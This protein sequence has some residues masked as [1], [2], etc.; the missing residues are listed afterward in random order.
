MKMDHRVRSAVLTAYRAGWH[1]AKNINNSRVGKT[2]DDYLKAWLA[3]P[4]DGQSTEDV[5]AYAYNPEAEEHKGMAKCSMEYMGHKIE[6]Q[7]VLPDSLGELVD[8]H[9]GLQAYL[10]TVFFNVLDRS[11]L[12]VASLSKANIT[13]RR[14]LMKICCMAPLDSNIRKLARTTIDDALAV[15]STHLADEDPVEAAEEAK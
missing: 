5:L 13:F 6:C 7:M 3:S 15:P 11:V 8:S 12:S 1:D 14:A 9:K 2:V 10:E 4:I